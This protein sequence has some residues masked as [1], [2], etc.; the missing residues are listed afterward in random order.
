MRENEC[1]SDKLV[2]EAANSESWKNCPR[3]CF[4]LGKK[5]QGGGRV[6][7]VLRTWQDLYGY[8][9]MAFSGS[10]AEGNRLLN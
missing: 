9:Q 10:E 2:E 8:G 3:G 4:F 6:R 1:H 5:W 7:N